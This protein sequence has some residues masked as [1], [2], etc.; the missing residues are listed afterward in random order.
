LEIENL[1]MNALGPLDPGNV[2]VARTAR[3]RILG[4]MNETAQYCE[5]AIAAHGGLVR[6]HMD[7]LNRELRRE[8][9]LSHEPPGYFVSLDRALSRAGRSRD[10]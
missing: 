5:A 8:L 2:T 6:C 9:H 1:P 3:R 10:S 4:Y 7:A